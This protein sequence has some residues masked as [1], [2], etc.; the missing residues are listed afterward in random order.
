M[1]LRLTTWPAY[2]FVGGYTCTILVK[3]GSDIVLFIVFVS[4]CFAVSAT[5]LLITIVND[6]PGAIIVNLVIMVILGVMLA[7]GV[8]ANN[9]NLESVVLSL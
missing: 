3:N 2:G 9:S 5:C 4:I 7:L 8:M 6:D 1:G